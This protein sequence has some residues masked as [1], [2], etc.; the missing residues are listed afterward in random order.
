MFDL[1]RGGAR[2]ALAV[3]SICGMGSVS[4]ARDFN[5]EVVVPD[6]GGH[7]A[8][9]YRVQGS[10]YGPY[11]MTFCLGR[12]DSYHVTGGG[13]DCRAGLDWHRAG[14][15]RVEI[16]LDYAR[17]GRGAG[18]SADSLSCRFDGGGAHAEVVVP[19]R[20]AR[21]DRLRCRYTPAERGYQ[22]VSVTARRLS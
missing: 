3:A 6:R 5:A 18:W 13:L 15:G 14:P 2:N 17:C 8:G 19:D 9:C 11:R 20:P 7:V 1:L 21:A 16:D 22:P 12:G 4:L 10:L